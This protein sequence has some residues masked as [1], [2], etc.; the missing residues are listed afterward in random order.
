[1][2]LKVSFHILIHGKI[3][4]KGTSVPRIKVRAG[5]VV[6]GITIF[7]NVGKKYNVGGDSGGVVTNIERYNCK[8]A[9][10]SGCNTTK[11]TGFT[12]HWRCP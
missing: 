3:I 8:L 10:F 5:N 9:Y 6:N 11:I 7:D 2:E 4:L 12:F 1:M